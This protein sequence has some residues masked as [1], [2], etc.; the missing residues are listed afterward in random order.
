M[1]VGPGEWWRGIE[2]DT[3]IRGDVKVLMEGDFVVVEWKTGGRELSGWWGLMEGRWKC[4]LGSGE[5]WRGW[6]AGETEWRP[7]EVWRC[8]DM[9]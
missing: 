2:F 6:G 3:W 5:K 7:G 9:V 1:E 8:G 4:S